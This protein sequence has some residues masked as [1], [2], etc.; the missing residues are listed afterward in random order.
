MNFC[1]YTGKIFQFYLNK[2]YPYHNGIHL[3]KVTGSNLKL[4]FQRSA[5]GIDRDWGQLLQ[6]SSKL[7]P[8]GSLNNLNYNKTLATNL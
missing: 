8:I 5:T 6:V 2:L 7:D 1:D 4:V 3:V